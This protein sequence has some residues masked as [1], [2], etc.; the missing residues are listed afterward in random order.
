VHAIHSAA[1]TLC[2]GVSKREER[3]LL[4]NMHEMDTDA[5]GV[6]SL[7]V[8]AEP[9]CSVHQLAITYHPSLWK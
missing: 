5:D 9:L 4:A 1:S 7:Q 3:L 6:I 8:R 2:A